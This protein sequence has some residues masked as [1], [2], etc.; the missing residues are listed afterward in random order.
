MTQIE[1]PSRNWQEKVQD[2]FRDG[3]FT[4]S[5]APESGRQVVMCAVEVEVEVEVEVVVEFGG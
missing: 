2:Y 1:K 4:R 3:K 5:D